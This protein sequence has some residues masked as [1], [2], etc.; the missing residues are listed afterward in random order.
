MLILARFLTF[1]AR[2]FAYAIFLA[3][4]LFM[5]DWQRSKR[6]LRKVSPIF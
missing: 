5:H 3:R 1:P 2:F 4:S 6:R